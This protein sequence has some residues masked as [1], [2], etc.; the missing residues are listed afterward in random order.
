[1]ELNYGISEKSMEVD[2][3][4]SDDIIEEINGAKKYLSIYLETNDEQFRQMASDE[5]KHANI[6]LKKSI[7]KITKW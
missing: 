5:L 2:E 1:M 3:D 4:K 7:F 6:L